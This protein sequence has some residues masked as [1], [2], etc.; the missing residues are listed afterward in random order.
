[1]MLSGNKAGNFLGLSRALAG[2]RQPRA[3]CPR[4]PQQHFALSAMAINAI[5][6]NVNHITNSD[7]CF[8]GESIMRCTRAIL[9][10]T[11]L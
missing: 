4:D 6:V 2:G 11:L 7:A 10:H 8:A 3:V 1:M 9:N 5:N